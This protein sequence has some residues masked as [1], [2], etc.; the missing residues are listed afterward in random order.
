[1][2]VTYRI[3]HFWRKRPPLRPRTDR[4]PLF[5]VRARLNGGLCDAQL[6]SP[7]SGCLFRALTAAGPPSARH[8]RSP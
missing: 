2:P 5:G 8:S 7:A 1:M 4:D 6:Q 3:G